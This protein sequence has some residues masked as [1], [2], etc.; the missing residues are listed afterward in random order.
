[1]GR[2]VWGR[3]GL[4]LGVGV[5]GRWGQTGGRWGQTGGSDGWVRWGLRVGGF[6]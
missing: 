5:G 4:G 6:A 3:W 1:M 2:W